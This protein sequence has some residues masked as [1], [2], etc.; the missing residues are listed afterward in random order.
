M[1][2]LKTILETVIAIALLLGLFLLGYNYFK[3]PVIPEPRVE[4]IESTE[5]VKDTVYIEQEATVTDTT[6]AASIPFVGEFY[7]GIANIEYDF[8]GEEFSL[9]MEIEV[10]QKIIT[11]VVTHTRVLP[12][13]AFRLLAT[14]GAT[15]FDGGTILNVGGG[16]RI[17]ERIDCL[18]IVTE[19]LH[20]G[21][22]ITYKF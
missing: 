19:K 21:I 12:P 7:S 13:D 1:S 3:P 20:A 17:Y 4:Y 14:V 15:R 18:I 8:I 9:D 22:Q 6:A 10:E 11:E 5:T 16:V 2:Y